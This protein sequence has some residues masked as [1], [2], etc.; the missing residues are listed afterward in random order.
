MGRRRRMFPHSL[1]DVRDTENDGNDQRMG[2]R[3]LGEAGDRNS[4]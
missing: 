2:S 4:R 1:I 3:S